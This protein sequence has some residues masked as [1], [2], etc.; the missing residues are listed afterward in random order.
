ML[1]GV[2]II[3]CIEVH[4][5]SNET[6][7]AIPENHRPDKDIA[8]SPVNIDAKV[9]D[10]IDLSSTQN[11]LTIKNSKSVDIQKVEKGG[12]GRVM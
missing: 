2:W 12:K 5:N 9:M 8:N 11:P 6:I 3:N 1:F 7:I 10:M 4:E